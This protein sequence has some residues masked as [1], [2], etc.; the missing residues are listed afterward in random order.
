MP[1]LDSYWITHDGK[2]L[3]VPQTHIEAVL[4]APEK[5]GETKKTIQRSYDKHNEKL[6]TE[7]KAREEILVRIMKR[8]FVRI[9]EYSNRWSI[10]TWNLTN[11]I[12]DAIFAWAKKVYPKIRD[13][14]ADVTITLFNKNKLVRSSFDKIVSGETIKEAKEIELVFVDNVY[15]LDDFKVSGIRRFLGMDG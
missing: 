2:I 9:R 11:K 15:E 8:G 10:Q 4:M 6:N 13:K 5:F 1:K 7:G 12:N 3:N 14:Y